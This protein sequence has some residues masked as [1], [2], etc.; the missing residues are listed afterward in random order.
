MMFWSFINDH[1][2]VITIIALVWIVGVYAGKK[3]SGIK[4]IFIKNPFQGKKSTIIDY[5]SIG[6]D[7]LRYK[8]EYIINLIVNKN[9]ELPYDDISAF[10]LRLDDFID[11]NTIKSYTVNNKDREINEADIYVKHETEIEIPVELTDDDV[12]NVVQ[13]NF[14]G[15]EQKAD[16]NSDII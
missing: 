13:P 16:I 15:N 11:N 7:H 14:Y 3:I 2:V 4:K 10:T 1:Y 5:S 6:D 9:Q 12:N 8:R